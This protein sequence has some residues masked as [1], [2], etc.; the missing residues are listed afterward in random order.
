ML[1]DYNEQQTV[2][3]MNLFVDDSPY[4]EIQIS[5]SVLFNTR[6]SSDTAPVE[7]TIGD[8]SSASW[9]GAFFFLR[10]F[11]VWAEVSIN[12]GLV[13]LNKAHQLNLTINGFIQILPLMISV[14][15]Y[16]K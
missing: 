8:A 4:L 10:D 13:L 3:Y 14:E 16:F 6:L 9:S 11:T 5:S 2:S 1:Y 15:F 7:F 12:T